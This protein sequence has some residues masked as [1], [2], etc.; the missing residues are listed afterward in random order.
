MEKT[1]SMTSS[2]ATRPSAPRVRYHAWLAVVPFCL[3]ACATLARHE[4]ADSPITGEWVD[5]SKSTASDTLVWVL[6]P[7]GDDGLLHISVGLAGAIATRR[8]FGR[9]SLASSVSGQSDAALC[10]VRRPGRDAPSC[11]D[12]TIDTTRVDARPVRRLRLR[13]YVGEHHT[14]DRELLQ[15]V[16]LPPSSSARAD[17]PTEGATASQ[18]GA[19]TGGFQARAVQPER[20]S[21]AT[22]AGTVAP[23]YV[24]VES[25]FERDR[26]AD[27]TSVGSVPT[28]LK[29]GLTKRT[30]LSLQLPFLGGTGMQSGFG[31]AAI[32]VKW[33]L[34]E[35]DP[36]LQDIA[37]L[38]QVKVA[39]GGSR[40]SGTTDVSLL[41]INSRTLGPVGMDI[42]VGVTRRG[43]DGSQAPTTATMWAVALGL[44]V[45][46]ALG[47][48][49]E[50]F[51]YPGTGGD[52]GGPPAVSLLTGPTLVL[53]R[54]LELDVGVIV[55]LRGSPSRGLYAGF[56]SNLGRLV[57]PR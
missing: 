40:G 11:V 39:S 12:F 1:G 6:A 2:S 41:L 43:G 45:R 34:F 55:P 57:G 51:G 5:V 50:W 19:G 8:H 28:V 15:R 30:Q 18:E 10:F 53:L 14:G 49:L 31:D 56:V 17:A 32:G 21:V 38:P 27:G 42:N 35:D 44:P 25:G 54:E 33:R 9:W 29:V 37:I 24:E 23:G 36:L 13:G 52:A 16:P 22:H 7:G 47:W 3:Q 48:A 26:A 46:G 4:A 20:P